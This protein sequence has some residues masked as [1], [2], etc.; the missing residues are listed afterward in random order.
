MLNRK[1]QSTLEYAI[2]VSVVIG[3][4]LVMQHYIKRGYQGKL[5]S[6]SDDMGEQFD[7]DAYTANFNIT[8]SSKVKQTVNSGVTTTTHQEDQINQK[9]GGESLEKWDK[10]K[11]VLETDE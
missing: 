9:T 7:P 2:I 10:S 8:Q 11:D 3:G 1:G 4:L 5:K 6:A